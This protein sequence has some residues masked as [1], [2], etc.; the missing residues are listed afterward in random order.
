MTCIWADCVGCPCEIVSFRV[1][2]HLLWTNVH[3]NGVRRSSKIPEG[4]P[5]INSVANPKLIP[6]VYCS[7][8]ELGPWLPRACICVI[9][10]P[11]IFDFL[12]ENHLHES[13]EPSAQNKN[14]NV[15]EC[16]TKPWD[17]S[18][19]VRCLLPKQ[20]C[21]PFSSPQKLPEEAPLVKRANT[22]GRRS[23]RKHGEPSRR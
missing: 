2:R 22:S 15:R 8:T 23:A 6:H 9:Q 11:G 17:S 19:G 5:Q 3:Q 4:C 7:V 13:K 16:E 18:F 12:W 21:D 1:K 14:A 10:W 20:F